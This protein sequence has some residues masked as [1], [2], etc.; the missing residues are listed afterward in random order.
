MNYNG[1]KNDLNAFFTFAL[2]GEKSLSEEQKNDICWNVYEKS[3]K[4]EHISS[5]INCMKNLC[6]T[7][8]GKSWM[9]M[10]TYASL[11]FKAKNKSEAQKVATEAI[12]LAKKEGVPA[13]DY[14]ATEDLLKKINKLK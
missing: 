3:D 14:Q 6:A 4:K 9:Y 8:E 1:K 10:D 2:T 12:E 13:E 5:A 7:P 11:L